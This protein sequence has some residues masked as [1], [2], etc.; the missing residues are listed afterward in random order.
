L[1]ALG[2]VLTLTA[3]MGNG[4]T[5]AK[6]IQTC[7]SH[8][9]A[10]QVHPVGS[11]VSFTVSTGHGASTYAVP[12]SAF[13]GAPAAMKNG[14]VISFCAELVD[15]GGHSTTTVTQFSDQGQSAATGTPPS[16]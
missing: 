5:S 6:D 12:K 16:I 8:L 2:A 1:L 7:F 11:T 15:I 4:A 13:G 3:C 9:P 10:S 14:D